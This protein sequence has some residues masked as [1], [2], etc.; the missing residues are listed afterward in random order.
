MGFDPAQDDTPASLQIVGRKWEDFEWVRVAA[1]WERAYGW[2]E[3]VWLE[4]DVSHTLAGIKTLES[5]FYGAPTV[6]ASERGTTKSLRSESPFE[7]Q[8]ARIDSNM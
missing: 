8:Q 6:A 2:R 7:Y 5:C 1:A 4:I 3:G